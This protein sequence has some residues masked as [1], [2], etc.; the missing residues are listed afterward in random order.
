VKLGFL[1]ASG[2]AYECVWVVVVAWRSTIVV[3]GILVVGYQVQPRDVADL[4]LAYRDK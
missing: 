2:R 4:G 3:A 1:R